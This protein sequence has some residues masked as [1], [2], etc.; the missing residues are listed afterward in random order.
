MDLRRIVRDDTFT[1]HKYQDI[2]SRIFVTSYLA[3]KNSGEE[4]NKRAKALA[5]GIGSQH[6][7][8]GIDEVYDSIV[9]LFVKATGKTP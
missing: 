4:T 8:I 7:N 1:P 5:E 9:N 2:V 3:T 6:L